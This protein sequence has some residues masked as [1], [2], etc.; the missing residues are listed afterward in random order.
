MRGINHRKNTKTKKRFSIFSRHFWLKLIDSCHEWQLDCHSSSHSPPLPYPPPWRGVHQVCIKYAI[1]I[2]IWD[3]KTFYVFTDLERP[4]RGHRNQN[5]NSD[6]DDNVTDMEIETMAIALAQGGR[7]A[8][9][10]CRCRGHS[11]K[12]Q[13]CG[14]VF[15]GRIRPK[16]KAKRPKTKV[17]Y[18]RVIGER[19]LWNNHEIQLGRFYDKVC[20]LGFEGC[21]ENSIEIAYIPLK[22]L[23]IEEETNRSE[24]KS[25]FQIE[26]RVNK[27]MKTSLR[28]SCKLSTPIVITFFW[29]VK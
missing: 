14:C 12:T 23:C 27:I 13:K 3:L 9:L 28:I 4:Q 17:S 11:R 10:C 16:P 18:S 15:V 19:G 6:N 21:F 25:C 5:N 8:V 1:I 24:S 20:F 26:N 22:S 29:L 7:S 2:K